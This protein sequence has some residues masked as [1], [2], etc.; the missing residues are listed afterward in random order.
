MFLLNISVLVQNVQF[1]Q[2]N[3]DNNFRILFILKHYF[4]SMFLVH[5]PVMVEIVQ[6][7]MLT[8]GKVGSQQS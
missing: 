7:I 4:C 2:I 3:I 5:C 8:E 1:I 6:S